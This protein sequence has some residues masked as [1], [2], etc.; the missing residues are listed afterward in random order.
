MLYY[1]SFLWILSPQRTMRSAAQDQ[2]HRRATVK[3]D[4]SSVI[5]R[6][7]NKPTPVTTTTITEESGRVNTERKRGHSRS[8]KWKQNP[9]AGVGQGDGE[10]RLKG[11][12]ARVKLHSKKYIKMFTYNLTIFIPYIISIPSVFDFVHIKIRIYIFLISLVMM[13]LRHWTTI[14]YSFPLIYLYIIIFTFNALHFSECTNGDRS[15][16]L[17]VFECT[18]SGR[19]E[20]INANNERWCLPSSLSR[21]F[22]WNSNECAALRLRRDCAATASALKPTK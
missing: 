4:K 5:E 6:S 18:C 14:Y 22:A 1:R 20:S 13:E 8:R 21:C 16:W 15:S 7:A 11:A 9:H 2:K 3:C 10:W 17:L 12:Y 19:R